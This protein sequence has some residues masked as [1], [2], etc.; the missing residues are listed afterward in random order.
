MIKYINRREA[1]RDYI[2]TTM[3][4]AHKTA[5]PVIRAMWYV[6]TDDKNCVDMWDEYMFGDKY[7]VAPVTKA[8]V[9][10]RTVYFPQNT[11]W[12]EI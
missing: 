5:K 1:M 2:R 9:R 6:F 11:K 12:K 10:E 3:E 7:L 8:G 4:Q